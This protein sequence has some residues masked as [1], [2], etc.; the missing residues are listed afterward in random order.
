V[1]I[2][3]PWDTLRAGRSRAAHFARLVGREGRVIVIEPTPENVAALEA[4][5]RRHRL[6]G[7]T[8]IP[9]AAWSGPA[10]LRFLVNPDHPASN[11]VEEVIDTPLRDR[12]AYER[13]EVDADSLDGLLQGL[14]V[15]RIRLLSINT[16]GSDRQ[17]FDGAARTLRRTEHVAVVTRR[18]EAW[19]E[20]CGFRLLGGDDRGYTY[21]R[22]GQA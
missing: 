22:E 13:I 17:I 16:N 12:G 21:G 19:L 6:D 18:C 5:A 9:R 8:V 3:A 4:F 14:S 2:G 1:Q 20:R 15:P 10:R 11:L 7:M